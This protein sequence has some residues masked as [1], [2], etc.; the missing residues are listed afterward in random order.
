MAPDAQR[1]AW[2]FLTDRTHHVWADAIATHAEFV[3]GDDAPEPAPL[4]RGVVRIL[5]FLGTSRGRQLERYEPV[6][7]GADVFALLGDTADAIRDARHRDPEQLWRAGVFG[8]APPQTA[9]L[10][11]AVAPDVICLS[12]VEA[13]KGAVVMMGAAQLT[14][15]Q[16][17]DNNSIVL[18]LPQSVVLGVT[19][20]GNGL[21]ANISSK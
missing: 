4:H 14:F 8:G 1:A 16:Q 3:L 20:I 10:F 12:R 7:P 9:D 15:L 18:T 2:Y 11:D 6:A 13:S 17:G 21:S 5:G 19:Q